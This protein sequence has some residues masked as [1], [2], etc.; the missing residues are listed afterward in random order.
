[1]VSTYVFNQVDLFVSRYKGNIRNII[2]TECVSL[3]IMS[4]IARRRIPL[5]HCFT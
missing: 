2:Q 1:M 3:I 5:M 4:V